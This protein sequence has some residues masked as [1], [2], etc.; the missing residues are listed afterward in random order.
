MYM[1]A[2]DQLQRLRHAIDDQSSGAVLVEMVTGVRKA[3]AEITA[4]DRLKT[5]PKGYG[6]DHPRVDLLCLKGLVAWK[7]WPVGAWLA[8]VKAKARLVEFFE[9]TDPLQQWLD[10]YVG[11]STLPSTDRR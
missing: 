6:K 11:P 8:T 9:Q 4:H 1:M 5:A 10:S 3:G 7:Q 2:T